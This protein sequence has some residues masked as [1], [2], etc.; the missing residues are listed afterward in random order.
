MRVLQRT[1]LALALP[2]LAAAAVAAQGVQTGELTGVV[3]SSDGLT[4]PGATVTVSSP[5]LQ[6]VRTVVS[7]SNGNYI[8]RALPPGTY[9]VTFEMSGMAPKTETAVVELGRQTVVDTKLAVAGVAESVNVTAE[10]TTAGLTSPT[11]GATYT[12]TEIDELPT[13]R[14]PALIAELSPGLTA[15]TPNV[16]QVTISGG[17]AYDNVF[18]IN[19]VDINDNLFGPPTTCSSKTPS[20][21]RPC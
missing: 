17:F 5:A 11:V 14:T 16:G 6:G 12:A 2:L 21:R 15:N 10:V 7:D 18:M 9:K 1:V 20:S 3:S 4:L 13:G 8:V 19:G